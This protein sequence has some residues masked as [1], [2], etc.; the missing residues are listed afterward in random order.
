MAFN[1]QKNDLST[2]FVRYFLHVR[3][4]VV[5]GDDDMWLVVGCVDDICTVVMGESG[6]H[7]RVAS[8]GAAHTL[9]APKLPDLAIT[10]S[11]SHQTC[12]SSDIQ[13]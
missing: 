10:K 4:S 12:P 3:S 11:P 8:R 6:G 1:R 13:W 5:V 7:W 9:T 2:I